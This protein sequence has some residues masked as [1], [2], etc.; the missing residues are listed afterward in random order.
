MALQPNMLPVSQPC[1]FLSFP[2]RPLRFGGGDRAFAMGGRGKKISE[3]ATN[4]QEVEQR[5]VDLVD[6]SLGRRVVDP[7]STL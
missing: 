1:L 3:F 2:L 4:K 5:A 7:R 6:L